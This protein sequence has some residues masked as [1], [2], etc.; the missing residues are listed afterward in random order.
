[1][2]I[3]TFPVVLSHKVCA[4]IDTVADVTKSVNKTDSHR[5]LQD[6]SAHLASKIM[7]VGV[8]GL[9]NSGKNTTLNALMGKKFLTTSDQAIMGTEVRI[10]H[11]CEIP[12]GN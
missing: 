6:V 7:Q 8:I 5:H 10:I 9:T 12:N 4:A 1:M 3:S 2:H 11:D